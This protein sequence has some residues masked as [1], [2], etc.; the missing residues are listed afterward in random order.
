MK[1]KIYS[2]LFE[3]AEPKNWYVKRTS[4]GK[5]IR[6]DF[7]KEYRLEFFTN[8]LVWSYKLYP[9]HPY[10]SD[11]YSDTSCHSGFVTLNI[12][13]K[14]LMSIVYFMLIMLFESNF[15]EFSIK[16]TLFHFLIYSI[17]I[18]SAIFLSFI[19]FSIFNWKLYLSLRK[20]E[21]HIRNAESIRKKEED[22][23]LE[24]DI[25]KIV[26]DTI[27]KNPKLARKIK[28]KNI[29]KNQ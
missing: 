12:G 16:F 15:T 17:N 11:K 13:G 20:A 26:N 1:N 8:G 21:Y 5:I 28:L 7:Y 18:I 19:S 22:E 14:I 10:N 23:K 29:E 9:Y 2:K 24:Q 4:S 25:V 3:F 27:A 6:N